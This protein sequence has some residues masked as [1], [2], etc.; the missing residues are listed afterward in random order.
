[1]FDQTGCLIHFVSF[2]LQTKRLLEIM[3]SF[4]FNLTLPVQLCSL[5]YTA[6]VRVAWFKS[7]TADDLLYPISI[8]VLYHHL[9]SPLGA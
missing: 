7:S 1:M 6:V 4:Y 8:R 5:I 2:F 3:H 9:S